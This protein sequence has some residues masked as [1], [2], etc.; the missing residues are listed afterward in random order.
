MIGTILG[1]GT[2]LANSVGLVNP[3]L[4]VASSSE[5]APTIIAVPSGAD[6]VSVRNFTQYGTAG[7]A[8]GA[9][10]QGTANA[11]I[12]TEFFWQRGMAQGSALATYKAAAT[13]VI[14]VNTIATGGIT[15]YDPSG[16][17]LLAQPRI[18]NPVAVSASTDAT[19]PVVTHTADTSVVVGSVVRMSSTAQNDVNGID[20]VVGTVT[21]STQFTLLTT[22]NAL[23]TAPG[24]IGGAGF[25]RV[26]NFASMFYPRMRKVSN[27]TRASVPTVGT[28]V[29]HGMT[30][31]QVVRFK[32][33]TQSGMVQLDGIVATVVTVVDD[34]SFT[35]SVDTA[36]MTAF[37]WPTIAQQPSDFPTMTP[38][39]EDTAA[40]LASNTAQVPTIAGLQI[41]AT[42][43]GILA[44]AAV[45][46]GFQ[47]LIL[48]NGGAGLIPTSPIIGPSG[49]LTWTSANV[50]T[51]DRL[52]WVAGK[53]EFGGF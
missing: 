51:P 7:A 22:T 9:Y 40:A 27:I 25:Y 18:G 20:M 6:W 4:G 11:N 41:N 8:A 35:I 31:G 52:Y 24:A 15:I 53:S 5:A 43:V 49:S 1:Q 39:G 34:F 32:I 46:T 14:S 47:G 33:P 30:P 36:A 44:D 19:R 17:N 50:V 45:N 10:F 3:N 29:A 38:V 12:G 2:F 13:G 23:A 37:S 48:G 26:I 21:S 16:N 28:T 42:S